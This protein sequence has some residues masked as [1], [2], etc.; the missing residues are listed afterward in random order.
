MLGTG[1]TQGAALTGAAP[2]PA[3]TLRTDEQERGW[4]ESRQDPGKV[5]CNSPN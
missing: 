2:V 1:Q 5:Y 3:Q 4:E